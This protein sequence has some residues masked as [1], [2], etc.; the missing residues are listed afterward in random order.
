MQDIAKEAGYT[1]APLY[2]YFAGKQEIIDALIARLGEGLFHAFDDPMPVGLTFAQKLE[3][4]LR[5]QLEFAEQWQEAFAVVFAIKTDATSGRKRGVKRV[6]DADPFIRRLVTW[7]DE[8]AQADEI[9]DC[10]PED[11]AYLLKGVM[12]AVYQQ[13]LQGDRSARLADRA[14]AIADLLLHGV[15]GKVGMSSDATA[16]RR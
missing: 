12:H 10:P 8:A 13:W 3:L 14:T 6:L 2:A 7:I 1:V 11:V 16:Q 5:R 15:A 4:L 9:G